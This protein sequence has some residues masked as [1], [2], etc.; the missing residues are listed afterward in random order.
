MNCLHL[1]FTALHTS[2]L[3]ISGHDRESR[4][5]LSGFS[6][7]LLRAP[8]LHNEIGFTARGVKNSYSNGDSKW[9]VT[10]WQRYECHWPLSEAISINRGSLHAGGGVSKVHLGQI[11]GRCKDQ[12]RSHLSPFDL[13][14]EN[15]QC[16]INFADAEGRSLKLRVA[17]G[18]SALRFL[19]N[20]PV[21]N[22]GSCTAR[23]DSKPKDSLHDIHQQPRV[24]IGPD[25]SFAW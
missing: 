22:P 11:N 3:R 12:D 13:P 9:R 8:A 5:A 14:L 2:G 1:H 23:W 21:R 19:Q 25:Q 4:S 24:T 16:E 20:C 7:L 17:P 15:R 18:I 10:W 6:R